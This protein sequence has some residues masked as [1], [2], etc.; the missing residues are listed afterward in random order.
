MP[1]KTMVAFRFAPET[2]R[3][4][5]AESRRTGL[6]KTALLELLI[7]RAAGQVPDA[8]RRA[9]EEVERT[10][11]KVDFICDE[12]QVD[13]AALQALR[14]ALADLRKQTRGPRRP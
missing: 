7:R 4:L 8:V 2:I 3:L 14:K 6:D 13:A 9:L 1:S 10:V 5:E 11:L 12:E